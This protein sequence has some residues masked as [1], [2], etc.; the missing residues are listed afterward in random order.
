MGSRSDR[1]RN[2]MLQQEEDDELFFVLV[3]AIYSS[4]YE[5]KIPVYTS[6]LPGARKVNEMFH[7]LFPSSS[8]LL[9][10]VGITSGHCICIQS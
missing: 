5:E 9:P 6:S 4:L 3:P 2:F 1:I 8:N 7:V 10:C